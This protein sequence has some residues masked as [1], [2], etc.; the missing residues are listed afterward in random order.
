VF[1]L[2]DLQTFVEVADAGGVSAAARR[3]GLS[4]SIVSR[5]LARLEENL[6][7]QLLARS[8]RVAALTEAGSTF[9]EHAR[10]ICAEL[11]AARE[12]IHPKG[13]LRGRLR[14]TVPISFGITHLAPV[15][16]ELPRIGNAPLDIRMFLDVKGEE[17]FRAP[18]RQEV[19]HSA[20]PI[21][22]REKGRFVLIRGKLLKPLQHKR[23]QR[24][25]HS[26]L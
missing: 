9:R 18:I 13:S 11:D 3:L 2:D 6:G 26:K 5:R 8:T 20:L 25:R 21:P 10:R 14:I 22:A 16:A 12:T 1:D 4:K 23:I 17:F 19:I 24:A 7:A 15:L